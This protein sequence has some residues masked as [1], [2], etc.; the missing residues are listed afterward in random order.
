VTVSLG[1]VDRPSIVKVACTASSEATAARKASCF[2]GAM[3]PVDFRAVCLVRVGPGS[4]I[5]HSTRV[6]IVLFKR[7][8]AVLSVRA[9]LFQS[10]PVFWVIDAR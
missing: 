3:P 5:A 4:L 9:T 7:G 1:I 10:S 6:G 2:L 8:E